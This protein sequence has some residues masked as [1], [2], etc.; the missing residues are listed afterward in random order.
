[1]FVPVCVP[2]YLSVFCFLHFGSLC[3]PLMS[4]YVMF[5]PV[6]FSSNYID[7]VTLRTTWKS[8]VPYPHNTTHTEDTK[9]LL[10]QLFQPEEVSRTN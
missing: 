7:S 2:M 10:Q 5:Y 3:I 1:M 9:I 6:L 4:C 8:V